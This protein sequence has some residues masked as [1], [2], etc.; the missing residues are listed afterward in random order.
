MTVQLEEINTQAAAALK[1]RSFI[2]EL[3]FSS[4][5][6]C[7]LLDLAAELKSER[8]NKGVAQS[9]RLRGKGVAL[10][11]EKTSTRTRCAFEVAVA[12]QGGFTTYLDAQGSQIGHKESVADT[13]RV[14]GRMYAGIEYRGFGQEIV[15]QLAEFAGV[16]VFN[17]LTNEWHP[18][19]MLADQLTMREHC[20]KPL[21]QVKLA[22]IGDA[23]SNVGNSVL[24]SSALAG[25]D[26]TII[27]PPSLQPADFVVS[28]AESIAQKT[29]AAFTITDDPEGVAGADFVYTDIWVSMG[30]SPDLYAERVDLLSPYRVDEELL[31]CTGNPD[32]KVLHDLP[33][34]HNL[35]T[36]MAMTLY[37]ETGVTEF[38]IT[39]SVFES[40]ADVIFD[41][42]ENRMHTIKAVLVACIGA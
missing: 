24:V 25:M 34:L 1:G 12:E 38:E 3:D 26:V 19:Q 27:A 42:A 5:E 2:K 33:A 31:A 8:I 14:L 13:A 30:E 40:N 28:A 36:K 15:E 35:D 4:G 11:F 6:W 9:K 23:R 32:V 22:Y 7:S 17:G 10:I 18:T 41:Q 20:R 37:R 21:S 39:D 29:G 16:P